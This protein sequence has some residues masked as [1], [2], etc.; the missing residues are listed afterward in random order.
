MAKYGDVNFETVRPFRIWNAGVQQPLRYRYY[1]DPKRAHLGA[2]I[3][4]RWSKVG[5]T[6]EVVDISIGRCIGQYTRRVNDIQFQGG[7]SLAH[8]N[9]T[10]TKKNGGK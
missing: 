7:N 2:L 1:S 8:V 10:P 6:L 9:A 4:I 3:E 5:I